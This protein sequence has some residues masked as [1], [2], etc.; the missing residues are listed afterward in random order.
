MSDPVS[1]APL[2]IQTAIQVLQFTTSAVVIP[3]TIALVRV[4]WA[5]KEKLGQINGSILELNQWK[6]DHM[7]A[8][9]SDQKNH[10][11]TREQCQELHAERLASVY[12]QI[13][14]LYQRYGDRRQGD[15]STD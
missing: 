2:D 3:G 11:L 4:L 8:A 12:R 13:D 1:H 10:I 14:A 15:R 6:E 9:E 5:V 7:E